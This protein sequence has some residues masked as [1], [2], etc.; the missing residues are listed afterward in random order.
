[1]NELVLIGGMPRSRS[2]LLCNIAAM[3]P[4]ITSTPTGGI[5]PVLRGIKKTFSHNQVYKAMDRVEMYDQMIGCLWGAMNGYYQDE[6]IV[7]E[8]NREWITNIDF[9]DSFCMSKC[10][11]IYIFRH[12]VDILRSI[13]KQHEKTS[14]LE[15]SEEFNME[16]NTLEDLVNHLINGIMWSP[17]KGLMD[18]VDRGYTHCDRDWE[19]PY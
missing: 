2:T 13:L 16:F 7:F 15:F 9:L 3:N 5:L 10:K 19:T 14:L 18:A 11:L 4:Q 12:P 6:N 8:K 1:M 17:V